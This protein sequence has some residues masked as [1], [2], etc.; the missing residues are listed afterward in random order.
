MYFFF[1]IETSEADLTFQDHLVRCLVS[2]YNIYILKGRLIVP[3][4]SLFFFFLFPKSERHLT[5]RHT[6]S[7]NKKPPEQISTVCIYKEHQK[8]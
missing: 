5:S 4:F 8:T 2:R 1:Y 6:K 7:K 3:I